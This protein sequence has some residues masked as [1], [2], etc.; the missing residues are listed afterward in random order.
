MVSDQTGFENS[1]CPYMGRA[2]TVVVTWGWTLAWV[3]RRSWGHRD[4]FE[5]QG[6][7]PPAGGN[8]CGFG[9]GP[10]GPL[11]LLL[12]AVASQGYSDMSRWMKTKV[13]SSPGG[14]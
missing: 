8:G 5:G 4:R 13:S 12:R 9:Y 1:L 7:Q 3:V 2:W 11:P 10:S 14:I 6:R